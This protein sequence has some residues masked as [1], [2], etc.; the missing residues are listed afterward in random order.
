MRSTDFLALFLSLALLSFPGEGSSQEGAFAFQIQG[1]W[2]FPLAEFRQG[3]EV[4][5]G[6]TGQG[7]NFGMGFTF[8]APGP[9]GAY[10]GFGQRHFECD[11]SVCPEGRNWVSTGF[12]VAL[13]LVLGEGRVRSW[14]QGGLHT[15][16]LEGR[17]LE[18][19]GKG[20]RVTSDGGVGVEVGTGVLISLG[21]RTSLSPGVRFGWG[22]VPFPDR[23][24]MGLR[25]L[26]VDLGILMG[27]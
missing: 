26:V 21:E 11:S 20:S 27:F 13:R 17:L 14:L 24:T 23:P 1:G 2:S 5:Q 22:E 16:R 9:F 3:G 10:L 15:H 19:G 7:P 6:E 12:D 25:Y 4:W 8:P 18:Q